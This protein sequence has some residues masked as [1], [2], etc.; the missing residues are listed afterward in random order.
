[1]IWVRQH[2]DPGFEMEKILMKDPIPSAFRRFYIW[3]WSCFCCCSGYSRSRPPAPASHLPWPE[4]S[5]SWG[6]SRCSYF[7]N[8]F[9]WFWWRFIWSGSGFGSTF[10]LLRNCGSR[11]GPWCNLVDLKKNSV[12]PSCCWGTLWRESVSRLWFVFTRVAD[13]W[14]FCMDGSGSADPWLWLMN[15]VPD[16]DQDSDPDLDIFVIDPQDDNKN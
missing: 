16:S 9:L 1:M 15:P 12:A 6:L 8:R 3:S 14:H 4:S 13:P 10:L 2:S 11:T 5:T 7:F